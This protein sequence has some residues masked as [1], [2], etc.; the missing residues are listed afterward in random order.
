MSGIIID[1]NIITGEVIIRDRT[2][3]EIE[4]DRAG[5][6]TLDEFKAQGIERARSI[7]ELRRGESV[8]LNPGQKTEEN[9]KREE[10]QA[11]AVELKPDPPTLGKYPMAEAEAKEE[12]VST[13]VRLQGYLDAETAIKT[14]MAEIAGLERRAIRAIEQATSEKEIS[15]IIGTLVDG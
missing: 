3:E 10:G 12:G 13:A 7:L 14:S 6:P 15:D 8:S 9:F 4:I 11:W 5:R 1:T 2:P